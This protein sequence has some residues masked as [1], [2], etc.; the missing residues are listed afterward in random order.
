MVADLD[1]QHLARRLRGVLRAL[2][3][4]VR[5]RDLLGPLAHVVRGVPDVRGCLLYTSRCV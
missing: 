2:G 5:V 1:H 3:A 4:G